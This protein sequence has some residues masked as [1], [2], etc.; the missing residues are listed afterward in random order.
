MRVLTPEWW[1]GRG[2][3]DEDA[4]SWLSQSPGHAREALTVR[5]TRGASSITAGPPERDARPPTGQ[6]VGL[7]WHEPSDMSRVTG[8]RGS[9]D[10]PPARQVCS[11]SSHE[12]PCVRE[13]GLEPSRPQALEPKSSAS[14]NSAT[15]ARRSE[16]RR[17][18]KEGSMR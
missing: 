15:R 18:G 6:A 1:W 5:R 16:E 3:A 14:A 4:P 10:P 12:D 8:A 11:F 2:P 13:K 17:V 7:P 9:P